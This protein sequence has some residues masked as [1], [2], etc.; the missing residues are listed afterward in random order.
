MTPTNPYESPDNPSQRENTSDS[1]SEATPT[2]KFL[3]RLV[4]YM[5]VLLLIVAVLGVFAA[6]V[7]GGQLPSTR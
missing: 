1:A 4:E 3:T 5:I 7:F 2:N 6:F